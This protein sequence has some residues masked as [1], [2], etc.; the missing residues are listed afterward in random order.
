VGVELSAVRL[1]QS[2]ERILIAATGSL[3]QASLVPRRGCGGGIHP[4][5]RLD[6]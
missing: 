4:L 6:R 2:P 5:S 3:E 1:D